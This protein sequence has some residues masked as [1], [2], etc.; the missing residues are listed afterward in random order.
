MCMVP[1]IPHWC[2][3]ASSLPER[4]LILLLD[5]SMIP[6]FVNGDQVP[7]NGGSLQRQDN[8]ALQSERGA[9]FTFIRELGMLFR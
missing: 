2:N 9:I 7:S 8:I 1:G 3:E 6:S 4:L 5:S